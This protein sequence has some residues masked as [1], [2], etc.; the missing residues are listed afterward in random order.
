MRYA[1]LDFS[2]RHKF[3]ILKMKAE[4]NYCV[5]SIINQKKRRSEYK[6]ELSK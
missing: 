4:V 6:G 5:R 2:I 3:C 1:L